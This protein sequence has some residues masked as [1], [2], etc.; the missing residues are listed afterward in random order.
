M[1]THTRYC[2]HLPNLF[3]TN[4][5]FLNPMSSP[6][7]RWS[8]N[9]G[10]SSF[11]GTKQ[12]ELY[13]RLLQDLCIISEENWSD[14]LIQKHTYKFRQYFDYW[15]GTV[16]NS[17]LKLP[18]SVIDFIELTHLSFFFFFVF[19]VWECYIE[20]ISLKIYHWF[21]RRVTCFKNHQF[22]DICKKLCEIVDY[23]L[24]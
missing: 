19:F 8:P 20:M 12:H 21:N 6:E 14:V 1:Y 2:Q 16:T 18:L 22:Y 13:S 7:G 3:Y 4:S 17:T 5:L 11:I 24:S 9:I 23:L 10:E 15:L